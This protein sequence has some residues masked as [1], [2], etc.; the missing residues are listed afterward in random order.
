[1]TIQIAETRYVIVYPLYCDKAPQTVA[2]IPF[3]ISPNKAKVELATPFLCGLAIL[4]IM[5]FNK[6][7]VI[8]IPI[9]QRIPAPIIINVS[10]AKAIVTK[11]IPTKTAPVKIKRDSP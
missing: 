10:Y 4:K 8:P 11:P 3:P 5:V 7:V 1:M 2:P 9:P 6:G